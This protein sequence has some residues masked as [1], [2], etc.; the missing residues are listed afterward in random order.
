MEFI[1]STHFQLR[2]FL[3]TR[4]YF[5]ASPAG[6]GRA[7]SEAALHVIWVL[8]YESTYIRHPDNM[9]CTI[10]F[11]TRMYLNPDM[12]ML[13]RREFLELMGRGSLLAAMGAPAARAIAGPGVSPGGIQFR[14]NGRPMTVG[15]KREISL[16]EYLRTDLGLHGAKYGC[17]VGVCGAC[18]VLI[19]RRPVRSCLVNVNYL[20]G[21][22]ITTIEGLGGETAL[23]PI[24]KT[25][26]DLGVFQCGYCA[27]GFILA[28]AA[29][30]DLHPHPTVEQVR[31]A[32]YGNLCRCTGYLPI[33]FA[34]RAVN[35]PDLKTYLQKSPRS[36]MGVSKCDVLAEA[37]VTGRL[38]YARDHYQPDQL[39][40][41]VV[42]S[43]HAHAVVKEIDVSQA[44]NVPG[45]IR[46]LT[47]QDI[48]GRKTFGS[49]VPDQPVLVR[50]KVKCPADAVALVLAESP[51]AARSGAEKVRVVYDPLPGIFSPEAALAPGAPLLAE[52]GNVC[53]T[54][55]A[56]KGSVEEGRQKAAVVVR[57]T[58]RTPLVEHAY[59]ETESCLTHVDEN[60]YLIV[61]TASQ[62]P[63]SFRDQIALICGLPKER[64]QLKTTLAGGAFGAKGDL[65]IQHLCA[66]GTFV[67]G[68]PVRIQLSRSESIRVHVKRHPFTLSY[69]TGADSQGRLTH[70]L[71]EGTADAG[72]YQSASAIVVE[73]AAT[74]ATGP[75]QI[76]HLSVRITGV[77][78]NN[79]NCGAMRGFGVPQVCLAME[80]QMDELAARLGL[81]PLEF[82]LKN[83]LEEG[84]T[85]QWGQVM[86]RDTGIKACLEALKNPVR[87]A[88]GQVSLN[89]GEKLGLGFA[90]CY[91]NASTPTW[92]P[93]G[94][95][96]VKYRLTRHGRF[97]ISVGSCELGQGLATAL[98]RIA[99]QTLGIPAAL[100]DI[101]F[102]S[103]KN[104]TSPVLT[105]SS[106]ATFLTGGAVADGAP[107]FRRQ[108]LDAA[109]RILKL[110]PERIDL[111]GDGIVDV[112]TREISATYTELAW[113]SQIAGR[114]LV[115]SHHYTPPITNI[116]LPERV[117]KTGPEQ[118]ILP[119][120]AY[121]A[122][123]ALVAVDPDSGDIRVLKIIAVQ[124]VGRAVNPTAIDGQIYG[125]VV[126]G[127]GWCL[128]E[129]LQV[130]NGRIVNDNLDTYHI[131][132][133]KDV[134]DIQP[135]I[136]EVPDLM[137]PFGAK[138]L[139]E[140]PLL[141]VA[142]AVLN[143]IRN[144][145]GVS[146]NRIPISAADIKKAM[147]ETGP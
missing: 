54:T 76:D 55:K 28:S 63:H 69:E 137:N 70:C 120:L 15:N 22:D 121:G 50:D 102:G 138:G 5:I 80:R 30:L 44:L 93:L 90:A 36:G 113:R 98:T 105:T 51:S 47:H 125:S 108:V 72:A 92:L 53:A 43:R 32:F 112:S 91:K 60:G 52:K 8:C 12:N 104:T 67:T 3:H 129:R 33:I 135:I 118:A 9:E 34:V 13:S 45:V 109:A 78:T 14:V 97:S 96:D 58:Y 71:V 94:R 141:P 16:L 103:T 24:Q 21:L 37:K 19:G 88:A 31:E 49:V 130:Q 86:G 38:E 73:D 115:M 106:Q 56:F 68:R 95:A 2:T 146:L 27:P 87:E 99:S 17:G 59:L 18:T 127:L 40:G 10:L 6:T 83:I 20:D 1:W 114:E 65:T 101:E 77:F 41:R 110:D 64:V 147:I 119:S 132:R 75:Y 128:K 124:D 26:A 7:E 122:Q 136:V 126:M 107:V 61:V 134:P 142:P 57:Q 74:F 62:T 79:P 123:A 140:V 111:A 23:D 39:T 143:A 133:S 35:N 145:V 29:L 82:R 11:E 144:A 89:P 42:W 25:M 4:I 66:L 131:P 85:S 84:K 139:G 117:E 46:V 100:I 48:P 81:D 116:H